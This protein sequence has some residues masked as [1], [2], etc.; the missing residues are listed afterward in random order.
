MRKFLSIIFVIGLIAL[1]FTLENRRQ[2]AQNQLEQLTVRLEQLQTGN[3]SQ[4]RDAAKKIVEQVRKHIQLSTDVEPTVATIVNVEE[5]RKRNPFYNK[6]EN[7]DHLVVTTDRAILYDSDND[8]ILD[9]IPV[10]LQ[11]AAPAAGAQ[12]APAPAPKP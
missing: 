4:N 1:I 5:L 8:L 2:A 10:Q 6:A 12:V 11:P 7:G 3:T 9:V